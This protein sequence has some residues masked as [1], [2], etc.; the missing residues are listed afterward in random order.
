MSQK[1]D[2]LYNLH[3]NFELISLSQPILDVIFIEFNDMLGV[4]D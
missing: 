1:V 2:P 3:E 4:C